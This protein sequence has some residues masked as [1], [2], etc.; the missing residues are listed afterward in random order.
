MIKS[1]SYNV[2]YAYENVEKVKGTVYICEK[3]KVAKVQ[4]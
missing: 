3:R 1:F 2:S 4:I